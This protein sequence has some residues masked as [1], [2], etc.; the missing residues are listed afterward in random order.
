MEIFSKFT[1]SDGDGTTVNGHCKE[2]CIIVHVR[3]ID[4]ENQE[5]SHVLPVSSTPMKAATPIIEPTQRTPENMPSAEDSTLD[6]TAMITHWRR[7][8]E[9]NVKASRSHA[10]FVGT[11]HEGSANQKMHETLL[12]EPV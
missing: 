1:T 3:K 11:Y 5:C 10:V 4:E 12:A 2:S 6:T 7:K 9:F 8:G